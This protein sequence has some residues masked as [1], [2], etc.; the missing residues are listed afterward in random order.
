MKLENPELQSPRPTHNFLLL[1]Y[2]WDPDWPAL[3]LLVIQFLGKLVI[4]NVFGVCFEIQKLNMITISKLNAFL[5]GVKN[6]VHILITLYLPIKFTISI[7][8]FPDI[9][10]CITLHILFILVSLIT[11]LSSTQIYQSLLFFRQGQVPFY[12]GQ[13]PIQ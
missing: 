3:L 7:Y 11:I 12:H 4:Q 2:P 1:Q 10:V 6:Q 9:I 8:P 13:W 5:A